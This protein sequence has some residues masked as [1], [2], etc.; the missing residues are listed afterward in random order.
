MNLLCER[1]IYLCYNECSLLLRVFSRFP[2]PEQNKKLR[3]HHWLWHI[4][5]TKRSQFYRSIKICTRYFETVTINNTQYRSPQEIPSKKYSLSFTRICRYPVDVHSFTS[6]STDHL[7]LLFAISSSFFV[8]VVN[9][10]SYKLSQGYG[11]H[12]WTFYENSEEITEKIE[13]V[14]M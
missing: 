9:I 3:L 5:H 12:V 10:I 2:N 7:Y 4:K 13:K 14:T 11:K 8:N 6:L 1:W